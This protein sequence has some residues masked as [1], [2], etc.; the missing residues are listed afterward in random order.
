MWA[1]FFPHGR[2]FPFPLPVDRGLKQGH[3]RGEGRATFWLP[4][5]VYRPLK[6]APHS[7][8]R[9]PPMDPRDGTLQ[10]PTQ[11]YGRVKDRQPF[12]GRVEV[13]LIP[14]RA[15]R[16][17]V[18]HVA[19]QIGR[20]R[21]AP[22][23]GRAMDRTRTADLIPANPARDEAHQVEDLG[24]GNL[25]TDLG[26][27]NPSHAGELHAKATEAMGPGLMI[28]P[29]TGGGTEKRRPYWPLRWL[30]GRPCPCF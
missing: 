22:R 29:C 4:S 6:Q 24:Q 20:E 16:E 28:A 5:E 9:L 1:D 14:R 15:T 18:V 7:S 11:L 19:L 26:E 3:F 21:T 25:R 8:D 23:G 17:A 30:V 27:A 2:A 12:H 10:L 13:Q